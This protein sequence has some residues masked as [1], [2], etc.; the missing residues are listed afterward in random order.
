M[1]VS[2]DPVSMQ[3]RSACFLQA[4]PRHCTAGLGQQWHPNFDRSAGRPSRNAAL[5]DS[6]RHRRWKRP[7]RKSPD[8]SPSGALCELPLAV[9]PRGAFSEKM[10]RA[11]GAIRF[12]GAMPLPIAGG[13]VGPQNST[14]TFVGAMREAHRFRRQATRLRSPTAASS[15]LSGSGTARVANARLTLWSKAIS[16]VAPLKPAFGPSIRAS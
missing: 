6:Q 8:Q 7:E 11:F 5:C 13:A 9:R 15:R 14:P 2:L 12:T 4:V 1:V 16:E 3:P 10:V